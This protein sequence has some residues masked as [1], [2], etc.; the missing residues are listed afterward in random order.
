MTPTAS[1]RR[2]LRR[3]N[4]GLRVEAAWIASFLAM[5]GQGRDDSAGAQ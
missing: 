5:T 4:P 3:G 1:L 2:A